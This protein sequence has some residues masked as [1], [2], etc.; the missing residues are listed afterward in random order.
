MIQILKVEQVGERSGD[1]S[2]EGLGRGEERP[3]GSPLWG[4]SGVRGGA[5]VVWIMILL[6]NSLV[7]R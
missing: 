5:S 6:Y 1:P 3:T 4:R 7:S 2:S